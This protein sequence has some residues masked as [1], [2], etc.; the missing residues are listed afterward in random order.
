MDGVNSFITFC[1]SLYKIINNIFRNY[2][3]TILIFGLIYFITQPS[4]NTFLLFLFGLIIFFLKRK[5]MKTTMTMYYGFPT[6][7]VQ[8]S[9][10]NDDSTFK[11][12]NQK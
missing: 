9:N 1:T 4:L 5:L 10:N 2:H 3:V 11:Y 6:N 7:N 12:F 8:I